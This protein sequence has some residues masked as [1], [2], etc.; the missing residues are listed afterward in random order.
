MQG[1]KQT[2]LS[3]LSFFELFSVCP[4][5]W[6]CRDVTPFRLLSPA[7]PVGILL[8][9]DYQETRLLCGES[10]FVIITTPLIS[11]HICWSTCFCLCLTFIFI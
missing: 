11:T 8:E 7:C 1:T 6:Q 4:M 10:E 5:H 3:Q 2:Q 9:T